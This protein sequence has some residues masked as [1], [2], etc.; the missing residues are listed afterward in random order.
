[1]ETNNEKINIVRDELE[2]TLLRAS[3][4]ACTLRLEILNREDVKYF[5]KP[6]KRIERIIIFIDSHKKQISELYG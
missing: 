3:Q 2:Q 4:L 6:I 5:D 1:M